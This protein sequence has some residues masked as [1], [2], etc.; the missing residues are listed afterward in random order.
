MFD[1]GLSFAAKIIFFNDDSVLV[2]GLFLFFFDSDIP[3][4]CENGV[5]Q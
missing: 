4:C 5:V 3:F 1:H 2:F